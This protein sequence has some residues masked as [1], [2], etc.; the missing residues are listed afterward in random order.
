MCEEVYMPEGAEPK[1]DPRTSS[2]KTTLPLSSS[3]PEAHDSLC[4][5]QINYFLILSKQSM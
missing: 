4:F 5:T 3:L 2:Q 1:K